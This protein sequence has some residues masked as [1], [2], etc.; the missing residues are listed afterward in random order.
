MVKEQP[1]TPGAI[2]ED[3]DWVR[4]PAEMRLLGPVEVTRDFAEAII[5]ASKLPVEDQNYLA[6]RIG[7]EMAEEK[8]WTD[9]LAASQSPLL[10]MVEE[11][12]AE[13]A[14]GETQPLEELLESLH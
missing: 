5:Q 7:E 14:R 4:P 13:H 12:R 6:W 3:T 11:A 10:Q 1:P 9:S 2:S 8:K